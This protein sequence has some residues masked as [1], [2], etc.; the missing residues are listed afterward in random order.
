MMHW[1]DDDDDDGGVY[2]DRGGGGLCRRRTSAIHVKSRR[3][4]RSCTMTFKLQGEGNTSNRSRNVLIGM[5]D[6]DRNN[7]GATNVDNM[8]E[9]RSS[10]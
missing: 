1:T 2:R 9:E 7:V 8:E 10:G 6:G 3:T 5:R 4:R